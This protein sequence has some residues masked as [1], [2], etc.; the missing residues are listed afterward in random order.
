MLNVLEQRRSFYGKPKHR[1]T[2]RFDKRSK[3]TVWVLDKYFIL[4]KS[5]CF[6]MASGLEDLS[7]CIKQ[8]ILSFYFL[9]LSNRYCG[10]LQCHKN[11]IFSYSHSYSNECVA[12]NLLQ[13][14][15]AI[16][17]CLRIIFIWKTNVSVFLCANFLLSY[18]A[19]KTTF[20]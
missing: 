13:I 2:G 17:N 7:W 4:R 12:F 3:I 8:I 20:L 6:L 10:Q 11:I 15:S 19:L 16:V 1:K 5:I 18:P 14:R 9:C